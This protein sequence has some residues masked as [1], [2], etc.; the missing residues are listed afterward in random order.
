MVP[1]GSRKGRDVAALPAQG[2]VC[3]SEWEELGPSARLL[4]ALVAVAVAAR[5]CVLSS[6]TE[7][8]AARSCCRFVQSR[9]LRAAPDRAAAAAREP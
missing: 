3:I 9:A 2:T 8:P 6:R 7:V 5:A 4:L 1:A